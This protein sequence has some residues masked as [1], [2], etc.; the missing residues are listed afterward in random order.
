LDGFKVGILSDVF[1]MRDV[2]LMWRV[3]TRV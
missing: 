1:L 2:E 3:G